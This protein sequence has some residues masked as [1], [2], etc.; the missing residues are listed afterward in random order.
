MQIYLVGGAVRD[1]LLGLPVKD[2][3]WL[4]VGATPAMMQAQGFI[5]V[6]RDFPVFIHPDTGEEYALARTERKTGRGHREF[7]FT[8]DRSISVAEDLLRRDLTINAIARADDGTLID[9]YGGCKDIAA[10]ILRHV[11]PAFTEDPLRVLRLM[12]FQ[13][14]FYSLGFTIAEETIE[15]CKAMVAGGELQDLS[16]ERVWAECEKALNTDAPTVFFSGLQQID[17]LSVLG[18]SPDPEILNLMNTD[19]A[20]AAVRIPSPEQRFALWLY[21][22]ACSSY[23][24]AVLKHL[25]LPK[26]Y[27]YWLHLVAEHGEAI[28]NW[29]QTNADSRWLTLKACHGLRTEGNVLALA[30]LMTQDKALIKAI[31]SAQEQVHTLNPQDFSRQGISGADLGEAIKKRQIALLAQSHGHDE[32]H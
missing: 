28:R 4:V 2:R 11:S 23:R 20:T 32:Q 29:R 14:R 1:K 7:A 6:G 5:Q 24:Q 3:D 31:Q 10:R 21:H 16:G 19:L 12:R 25:P 9:P 22:P 30:Q 27:R 15:L 17:A 18:F 8:Y 26:T 13:A